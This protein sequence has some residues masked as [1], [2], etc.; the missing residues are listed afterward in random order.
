M[1][2]KGSDPADC[3]L[4]ALTQF[5]WKVVRN[6][7]LS[8]QRH[9]SESHRRFARFRWLVTADV[10][11]NHYAK[12]RFFRRNFNSFIILIIDVESRALW[13]GC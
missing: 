11:G 3:K 2:N 6:A 1:P 7:V 8:T 9:P 13:S 10:V 5:C 4:F 12:F